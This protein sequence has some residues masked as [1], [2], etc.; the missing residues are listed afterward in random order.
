MKY[1]IKSGANSF[2]TKYCPVGKYNNKGH[3]KANIVIKVE[4]SGIS[5]LYLNAKMLREALITNPEAVKNLLG[6][7]IKDL[8]AI[9]MK[10]Q[11]EIK[12]A[13]DVFDAE[14]EESKVKVIE[15]PKLETKEEPKVVVK[16]TQP[17]K[18]EVI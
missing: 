17:K 3:N 18:V 9:E 4:G 16:K 15:E 6:L 2:A 14:V 7:Q 5:E 12:E 10:K 1:I 13:T 11:A 8:V